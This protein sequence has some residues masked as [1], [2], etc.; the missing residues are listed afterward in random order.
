MGELVDLGPQPDRDAVI[1]A[2]TNALGEVSTDLAGEADTTASPPSTTV[3]P[4]SSAPAGQDGAAYAP[5]QSVARRPSNADELPCVQQLLGSGELPTAVA[6]V[7]GIA[8]IV[9]RRPS[10]YEVYEV[11]TCR[12]SAGR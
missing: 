8:V 6:S 1:A 10:G 7:D 2:A 11:G 3:A 9:V 12:P 5:D 4:G